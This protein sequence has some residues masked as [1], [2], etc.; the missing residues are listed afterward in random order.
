[1]RRWTVEE[2]VRIVLEGFTGD[3]TVADVCREHGISQPQYYKW[4]NR[5]LEGAARVLERNE[6]VREKEFL[7][8]EIDKLQQLVGKQAM[9]IDSLRELVKISGR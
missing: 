2:K 7:R 9:E 5:F 3:R 6:D 1:M 8:K 4:K